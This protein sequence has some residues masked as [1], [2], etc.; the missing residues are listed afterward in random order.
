MEVPARAG[1]HNSTMQLAPRAADTPTLM[2]RHDESDAGRVG[3]IE[4][5]FDLVFVVAVGGSGSIRPGSRT[6]S[7]G[8]HTRAAVPAGAAARGS[9]DVGL[10]FRARRSNTSDWIFHGGHLAERCGLFVIIA[11]GESLLV[12]GATFARM[13]WTVQAWAAFLIAVLGSILL[14]W[15]YFDTGAPRGEQRISN[16]ENPGRLA[17]LGYKYLHVDKS[18]PERGARVE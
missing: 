17:R 6:G 10:R 12:T 18:Y 2:R 13:P 15:I 14:R 5:F 3:T 11:L 9:H 4:L 1:W 7:T 8:A 16:S